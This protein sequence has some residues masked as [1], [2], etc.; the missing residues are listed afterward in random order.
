MRRQIVV[1]MISKC[2]LIN[3]MLIEEML[4]KLVLM[5]TKRN[6]VVK[7]ARIL[8]LEDYPSSKRGWQSISIQIKME[9]SS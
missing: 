7:R 1:V 3:F 2:K 6:V 5:V 9:T 8:R 4:L